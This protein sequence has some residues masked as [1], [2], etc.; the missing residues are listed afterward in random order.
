MHVAGSLPA[1]ATLPQEVFP[2]L[3]AFRGC[4]L[5]KSFLGG[6]VRSSETFP[7]GSTLLATGSLCLPGPKVTETSW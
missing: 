3:P 4:R 7:A 2:N 1:R 5:E 6:T